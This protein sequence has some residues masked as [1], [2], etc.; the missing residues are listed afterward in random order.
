MLD[1]KLYVLNTNP[2]R[3]RKKQLAPPKIE[4]ENTNREEM[5]EKH[6]TRLHVPSWG[7]GLKPADESFI[8]VKFQQFQTLDPVP[9]SMIL[10]TLL[11][12]P[13]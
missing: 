1:I 13:I 4:M 3:M 8:S 10:S 2:I 7:G 12:R 5:E 11:S 9:K 6:I